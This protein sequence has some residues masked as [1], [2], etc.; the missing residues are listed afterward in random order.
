MSEEQA[1]Q[2][3]YQMQ[4]LESYFADLMQKENYMVNVLREATSAIESIKAVKEDADYETLVPLGLGTFVKAKILPHEKI[5]LNV[6]AGAAMEKDK[7]ST[8]NYIES[9][10]K[11]I[12][13]ALKETAAQK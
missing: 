5:V 13:I 12:E 8:I 9:R 1:Q 4:I 10:I 3:L 2:L 6:G 7:E 11:E